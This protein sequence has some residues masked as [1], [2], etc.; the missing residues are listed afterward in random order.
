LLSGE[1]CCAIA[2]QVAAAEALIAKQVAI[3]GR[4]KEGGAEQTILQAFLGWN[5]PDDAVEEIQSQVAARLPRA[6][7][8]PGRP[9]LDKLIKSLGL[10]MEWKSA[11]ASGRGAYVMAGG[12]GNSI[13]ATESLTARQRTRISPAA[14][15]GVV[16][17]EIAE[18]NAIEDKLKF[19][20][21]NGAYLAIS[22]PPGFESKARIELERRFPVEVCD[23]DAAFITTMRQQAAAA[24]ADWNVVIR[25]DAAAQDSADWKNLQMLVERCLP[26]I[27][28]HCPCIRAGRRYAA[29]RQRPRRR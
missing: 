17:S 3:I 27:S 6:Q 1:R 9:Q 25:A 4:G 24:G 11:A 23:L 26:D 20:A 7:Q 28:G 15:P 29:F 10:E 19:A 18:A 14:V 12:E 16:P 5:R 22:V 13:H 8:L 2:L 21:N